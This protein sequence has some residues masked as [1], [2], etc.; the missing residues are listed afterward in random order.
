MWWDDKFNLKEHG[1]RYERL[2]WHLLSIDFPEL[3]KFWVHHV[4][5]L[6]NR[7]DDTIKADSP[8]KLFLREDNKIDKDVESLIM[9][10]YSVFYYL[11]RASVVVLTESHL[12]PED[13][14]FYLRAA[15]ENVEDFIGKLKGPLKTSLN[16]D[17]KDM[18][19]WKAIEEEYPV[20]A[21]KDYG[22]AFSHYPRLGRRPHLEW[23]FIP[24]Y[25]VLKKARFSWSYV[26]KLS[27]HD[28]ENGRLYLQKFRVD[29]MK[30]LNP[31]WEKANKAL[32]AHREGDVYLRLY[33]LDSK[34]KIL[35]GQQY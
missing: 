33:R 22:E 20:N 29:L 1:D 19:D 7:I 2:W 32:D 8:K 23:E 17:L 11:A 35:S 12:F 18:P 5:P 10:S 3:E 9:R 6:T 34:G 4:V 14:F 24:K 30:V 26:Q 13:A 15:T 25:S 21:I 16:L 31:G 27:K 28:F